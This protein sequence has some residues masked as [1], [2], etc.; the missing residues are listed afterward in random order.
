MNERTGDEGFALDHGLLRR[1]FGRAAASSDG[2]D[3]LARE[4][5]RR[6]DERLEY[7]RIEPK[8]VLDLGCGTGPDLAQL[9][10][11]FPRAAILAADF[12]APMLARA[13][14]RQRGEAPQPGLLRRLLGSR[15]AP[16]PHAVADARSLPFARGSLGMVW[17]NLMLPALDDPLPALQEIH[18]TLEVGG[19]LMF[20]TLGPDSLR[21]LRAALPHTAG[22]RVHRF[23]DMHD[24]GDALVKAG[25]ADPVMDMEMLTLTYTELDGLLSD[26]RATGAAN[27]ALTR[28]RGLS[29]R[30]GW[31]QARAAYEA[32]RQDGRLP[33]TFEVIQG[34]A[35]KAAPKTTEDGR[36]I[37]R[38]QPRPTA[39]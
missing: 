29:G 23:I 1:R 6:M 10:R 35:W 19:L 34:H 21:E 39:R 24:L 17:S 37:V 20:S 8:R 32:L 2:A 22:E 36:S 16:L 15:P 33:A 27:A 4:I 18:R 11:R 14:L 13:G 3:V 25:F 7:I 9:A 38:F 28:P 26:L 30:T 31:A 5:A 12:A